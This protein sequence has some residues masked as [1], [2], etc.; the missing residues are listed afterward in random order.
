[1]SSQYNNQLK[2][3]EQVT[4]ITSNVNPVES[5][6]NINRL[7]IVMQKMWAAFNPLENHYQS[8]NKMCYI[9]AYKNE[10]SVL[11]EYYREIVI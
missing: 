7:S 2:K 6:T 1:M 3:N 11:F 9:I 10:S 8:K 4:T 5:N